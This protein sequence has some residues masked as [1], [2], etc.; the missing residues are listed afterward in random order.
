MLVNSPEK[1]LYILTGTARSI[2]FEGTRVGWIYFV[3]DSPI[4]VRRTEFVFWTR[5]VNVFDWLWRFLIFF[6]YRVVILP[7]KEDLKGFLEG[8]AIGNFGRY[9]VLITCVRI[10]K[11]PV[12]FQTDYH[13]SNMELE[14]ACFGAKVDNSWYARNF[15]SSL[16]FWNIDPG[17]RGDHY[18]PA[19]DV[20]SPVAWWDVFFFTWE[21]WFRVMLFSPSREAKI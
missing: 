19:V 16:V 13:V 10:F 17:R 7:C 3:L 11:V 5:A 15:R 6:L 18:G 14:L 12:F 9:N 8:H 20:R 21:T 1:F 4:L 2:N